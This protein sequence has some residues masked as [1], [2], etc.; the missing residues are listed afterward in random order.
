MQFLEIKGL[1]IATIIA[2]VFVLDYNNYRLV[3]SKIF[4]RKN[5]IWRELFPSTI[6]IVLAVYIKY[7]SPYVRIIQ[8]SWFIFIVYTFM[9]AAATVVIVTILYLLS[10][11]YMREAIMYFIPTRFRNKF[12]R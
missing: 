8:D 9:T 3:F 2:D 1:L 7:F 4:S 6:C 12:E 10:S 5:D 11:K